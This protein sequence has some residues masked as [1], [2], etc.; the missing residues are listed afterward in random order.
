MN[1]FQQLKNLFAHVK[2]EKGT[3]QTKPYLTIKESGAESRIRKIS[4]IGL[5]SLS[6]D[7]G[8]WFLL[9][10]D[11][12]RWIC[13]HC[14]GKAKENGQKCDSKCQQPGKHCSS[15]GAVRN[16][17]QKCLANRIRI[18]SPLLVNDGSGFHQKACDLI[19]FSER[20]TQISVSYIELKSDED[21]DPN[22]QPKRAPSPYKQL[23]SMSRFIQ[24]A[25]SI[26]SDTK[27]D[28]K[29][30]FHFVHFTKYL[31]NISSHAKASSL[32]CGSLTDPRIHPAFEKEPVFDIQNFF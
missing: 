30:T 17:K 11:E 13:T 15:C 9:K 26:I 19:I 14:V 29:E 1:N 24:Y 7:V 21:D 5:D 8:D 23:K 6:S 4:L 25:L 2:F 31:K 22:S 18:N 32:G 27:I 20:S 3:S 28:I 16:C 12:E 10:P